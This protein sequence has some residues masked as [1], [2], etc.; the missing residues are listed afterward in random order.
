MSPLLNPQ[1]AGMKSMEIFDAVVHSLTQK[2]VMVI[3]NIHTLDSKWCCSDNDGQ[4][5][6]WN[7]NF[8]V[9]DFLWSVKDMC[10]R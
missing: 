5:L 8:T 1:L 4:G 9:D 3:L 7:T 2:G 10:E 6:W